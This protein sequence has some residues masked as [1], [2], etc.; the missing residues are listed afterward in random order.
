M[1]TKQQA[2]TPS[3]QELD[4]RA[5]L[6]RADLVVLGIHQSANTLRRWE[7]AGIF[8]KRIALSRSTVA[9]SA[10]AIRQHLAGLGAAVSAGV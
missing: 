7:A 3:A 1:K 10:A 4:A 2:V 6:S 9:W 8:P 5:L